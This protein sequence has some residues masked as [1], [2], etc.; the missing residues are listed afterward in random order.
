MVITVPALYS[1]AERQSIQK[2]AGLAGLN[3]LRIMSAPAA[4]AMVYNFYF[5][6]GMDGAAQERNVLVFD[7]G[8]GTC[9]VA[10]LEMFDNTL[11]VNLV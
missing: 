2:A 9:N 11:Q 3:I 10:V 6:H 4:A 1:S 7:L 8:G 5:K